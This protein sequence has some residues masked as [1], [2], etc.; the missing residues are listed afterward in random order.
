M[1]G[2]V[3]NLAAVADGTMEVIAGGVEAEPVPRQGR[4]IALALTLLPL[5]ALALQPEG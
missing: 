2:A 3:T 1:E 5:T 4:P